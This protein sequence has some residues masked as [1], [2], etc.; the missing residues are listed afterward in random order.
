MNTK[1][2]PRVAGRCGMSPVTHAGVW[3]Q[4]VA[5][6]GP[7]AAGVRPAEPHRTGW[8][9]PGRRVRHWLALL[10]FCAYAIAP[11][12]T[13]AA[14]APAAAAAT[15]VRFKWA[16]VHANQRGVARVVDFDAQPTV[17][18]GDTMR[19]YFQPL[20]GAYIYLFF[21]DTSKGL[22]LVF[23][24]SADFYDRAVEMGHEYFV[25]ETGRFLMDDH[26]GT[27]RFYLFAS[28]QRLRELEQLTAAFQAD[29]APERKARL[30]DALVATQRQHSDVA[31]AAEKGVPIAGTVVTRSAPEVTGHATLVEAAGFY[32]KVLRLKHE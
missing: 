18:S 7:T 23:P 5:A 10:L 12:A 17:A 24:P 25:P 11:V 3:S 14:D 8:V 26:P 22:Q 1:Q 16:F 27:E 15:P 4:P 29:G 9:R 13:S 19:V 20:E 31:M 2:G 32:C 28:P 21:L 6:G 30:L